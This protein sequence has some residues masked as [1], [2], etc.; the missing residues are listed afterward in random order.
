MQAAESQKINNSLKYLTELKG[1]VSR[2]ILRKIA[3]EEITCDMLKS[4]YKTEREKAIVQ[5]LSAEMQNKKP[6]I[7][8]NATVLNKIITFLNNHS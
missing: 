5:L 3:K 2:D 4:L 7:T 8:K 1:I 6:K